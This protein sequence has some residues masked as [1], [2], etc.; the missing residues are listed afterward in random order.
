[1]EILLLFTQ[2]LPKD[3]TQSFPYFENLSIK[4]A[5]LVTVVICASFGHVCKT[6]TIFKLK[7]LNHNQSEVESLFLH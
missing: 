5:K 4:C 3:I 7:P 2:S 1:M 6:E